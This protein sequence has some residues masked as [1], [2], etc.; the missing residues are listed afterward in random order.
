MARLVNPNIWE[1]Q[2]EPENKNLLWKKSV[3]STGVIQIMKFGLNGWEETTIN[4]VTEPLS[5]I[6]INPESIN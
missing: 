3:P 5:D 6:Y 1:S 2:F 4:E